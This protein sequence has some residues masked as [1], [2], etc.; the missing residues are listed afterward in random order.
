MRDLEKGTH[1]LWGDPRRILLEILCPVVR[2]FDLPL[3]KMG[4]VFQR[5]LGLA[6]RPMSENREILDANSCPYPS[7]TLSQCLKI[8][9]IS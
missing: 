1:N 7:R 3:G 9:I 2:H 4:D 5:F 8:Q 6:R